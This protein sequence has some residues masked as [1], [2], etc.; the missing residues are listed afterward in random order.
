MCLFRVC[1][2]SPTLPFIRCLHVTQTQPSVLMY[3]QYKH[4]VRQ[5]QNN[6]TTPCS[7]SEKV[8]TGWS[9]KVETLEFLSDPNFLLS[10]V[11][12]RSSE[13]PCE[14]VCRSFWPDNLNKYPVLCGAP[15]FS[16]LVVWTRLGLSLK[17]V[18]VCDVTCFH[19][20]CLTLV[21]QQLLCNRLHFLFLL[22]SLHAL[23]RTRRVN[24]DE[25]KI[26]PAWTVNRL[27]NR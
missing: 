27:Q 20:C 14:H 12:L 4:T 26:S 5:H 10:C 23:S 8:L 3:G 17:F 1:E 16:T 25:P 24:E 2:S 6:H 22:S 13:R 19:F 7:F 9:S 21:F 15:F 18:L 11:P